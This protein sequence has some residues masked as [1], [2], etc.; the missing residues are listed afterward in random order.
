MIKLIIP[1]MPAQSA[2]ALIVLAICLPAT[3][4]AKAGLK[5]EFVSIQDGLFVLQDKPYYYAGIN[6]WHGAYMGV[7]GEHGDRQRLLKELDL[8]K[9]NNI[10]NL[11]ILAASEK[12]KL[13]MS[14]RPAIQTEPGQYNED[15]LRGLDFLLMEMGK[16]DMQAV[17]FLNNFWQWSSGMSQYVTWVTGTPVVDPDVD[18]KWND[19]M[20]RSA[21]FYQLNE[22]QKH[23]RQF[24]KTLIERKNTYTGVLYRD[25]PVI[26]S[27]ELANEPRPGGLDGGR[28]IYPH[29][30]KWVDETAQYI[31]A[32]DSNHL[33]TTGSEG[34]RGTLHDMMLFMDSHAVDSIDYLTFHLWVKNWNWFDIK[35]PGQTYKQ[36]LNNSLQYINEHIDVADKMKKPIVL[37]EFGVERDNADYRIES[38][39]V[40]RDR[41]FREFYGL[42]YKRAAEGSAI[43]GSNVW[44]WGGYGRTTRDDFIWREGDPFLGDPPQEAQGLNSIFDAD[45][46][47]LKIIRN[48]AM[49]MRKLAEETTGDKK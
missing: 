38:T 22:A 15:I 2:V 24:I 46:S 10:N 39:T 48:H 29:F 27:W 36:A 32:L 31:H 5:N 12:S 34:A 20:Q 11:R 16:R 40:Y 26:M 17:L 18:G 19:F 44:A 42:F 28:E 8:L 49:Q 30:K 13:K 6:F 43:G 3:A 37:E 7:E 21:Y 35:N 25:D 47:T 9:E 4:I 1:G 33:V 41:F 45:K 14:L 23:Y